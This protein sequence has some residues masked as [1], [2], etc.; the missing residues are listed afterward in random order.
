MYD[1]T[2]KSKKTIVSI[3]SEIARAREMPDRNLYSRQLVKKANTDQTRTYIVGIITSLGKPWR[4]GKQQIPGMRRICRRKGKIRTCSFSPWRGRKIESTTVM[5]P[6][7]I[8][9]FTTIL[10]KLI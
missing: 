4:D 3:K 7:T 2:A 6:Q 10:L 1:N 9:M 5:I 8:P